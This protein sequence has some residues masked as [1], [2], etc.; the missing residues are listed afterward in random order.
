MLDDVSPLGVHAGLWGFAWTPEVEDRV[1]GRAADIGFD[2]IEIPAVDRSAHDSARTRAALWRHGIEASVSLALG[3]DDDITSADPARTERGERR[4]LEA[5]EFAAEIDAAFVGGVVFS[6]MTRYVEGP[7][8]E[9]R[10]RSLAVLRRVA[11]TAAERDITI[12]VEY[13]NRYESNLLNTAAQTVAFVDELGAENVVVHLDTFHAAIEETSVP[14]AI[15]AAGARLG[16]VH[17][18]ESHRGVLGTGSHDWAA[19]GEALRAV[20][21][22]G[23]ITVETFSRAVVDDRAATDIG[24]WHASWTDPDAAAAASLSLLRERLAAPAIV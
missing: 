8:R 4:L 17:A 18:S 7:T 16:Y 15:A 19:I 3:I 14:A 2:L 5:V 6:A 1:I 12:G 21:Y 9:G 11:D 24:L 23:P 13:V 22:R 10:E 20:D